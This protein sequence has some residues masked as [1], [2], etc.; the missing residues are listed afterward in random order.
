MNPTLILSQNEILPKGAIV[1][2][3]HTLL[4]L[5]PFWPRVLA[6]TILNDAV[7]RCYAVFPYQSKATCVLALRNVVVKNLCKLVINSVE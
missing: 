6:I 5:A 4:G 3:R 7:G 2:R 1:F